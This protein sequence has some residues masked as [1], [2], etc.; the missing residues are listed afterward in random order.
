[1]VVGSS[2]KAGRQAGEPKCWS[3]S[4]RTWPHKHTITT[5]TGNSTNTSINP[6]EGGSH[7]TQRS[8]RKHEVTGERIKRHRRYI[9]G[10]CLHKSTQ[11]NQIE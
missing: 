3:H 10:L 4:L 6:D 2:A 9:V 8:A 11:E 1:M 7:A 5:S